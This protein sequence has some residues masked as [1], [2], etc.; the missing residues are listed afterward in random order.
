MLE[1]RIKELK[2]DRAAWKKH[3]KEDTYPEAKKEIAEKIIEING[4][5]KECQHW[6][7]DEQSQEQALNIADVSERTLGINSCANLIK[8]MPLDQ[9]IQIMKSDITGL[10]QT[11]VIE[12]ELVVKYVR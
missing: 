11:Q 12:G 10:P 7:K 4:A 3:L 1:K 9:A 2:K 5:I 8:T 6:Q